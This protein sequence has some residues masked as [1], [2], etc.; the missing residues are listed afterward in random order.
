MLRAVA[1][2]WPHFLDGSVRLSRCRRVTA[3]DAGEIFGIGSHRLK[4]WD[5][6]RFPYASLFSELSWAG[7]LPPPD[8]VPKVV[9]RKSSSGL[10]GG[11]EGIRGR[12]GVSNRRMRLPAIRV[13]RPPKTP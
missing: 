6:R 4:Q 13:R 8:L 9:H 1:L 2:L 10:H 11:H 7:F 3:A 5:E 12:E